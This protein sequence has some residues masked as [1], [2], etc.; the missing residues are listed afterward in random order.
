LNS[1]KKANWCIETLQAKFQSKQRLIEGDLKRLRNHRNSKDLLVKKSYDEQ[2]GALQAYIVLETTEALLA[3]ELFI[4]EL[5][6]ML[7][8]KPLEERDAYDQ[9]NVINGWKGAL[10][11]LLKEFS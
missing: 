5:K 10:T 11:E 3:P 2:L 4:H 1:S 8:Q 9:E 6:R 7:E